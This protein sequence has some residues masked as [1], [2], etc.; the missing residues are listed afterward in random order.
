MNGFRQPQRKHL[1]RFIQDDHLQLGEIECSLFYMIPHPARGTD[2]NLN[3]LFQ[4]IFLTFHWLTAHQPRARQTAE[5][6]EVLDFLS[7]LIGQLA[8]RSED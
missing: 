3:P 8:C 2:D 7:D 5:Q 4:L 6:A 1:I